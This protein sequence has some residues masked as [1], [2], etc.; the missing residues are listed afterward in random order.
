[1]SHLVPSFHT[2]HI[3]P[4]PTF[5]LFGIVTLRC[6]NWFVCVCV[7]VCVPPVSG[8]LAEDHENG[9]YLVDFERKSWDVPQIDTS[10]DTELYSKDMEQEEERRKWERR[11]QREME[12]G[13]IIIIIISSSILL[14][15]FHLCLMF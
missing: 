5:Y 6:N 8:G 4:K 9:K 3:C 14:L 2:T 1:M 12:D 7:C 13:T 11:A 15:F 10:S